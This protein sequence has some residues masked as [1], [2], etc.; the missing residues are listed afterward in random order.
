MRTV[1]RLLAGLVAA[2]VAAGAVT[3]PTGPA[4]AGPVSDWLPYQSTGLVSVA[5]VMPGTV[6][7][8]DG[9]WHTLLLSVN[10]D[11]G[12]SG[13]LV[14]WTCAPGVR[15]NYQDAEEDWRCVADG[16]WE[17]ATAVDEDGRPLVDVRV[18]RGAR[19]LLVEGD[20]LATDYNGGSSLEPIRLVARARGSAVRD[21]VRTDEGALRQITVIRDRTKARGRVLGVR[22]NDPYA[23]VEAS[24]IVAITTYVFPS[25]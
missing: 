9:N 20:V 16:V 8:R 14:D 18:D 10:G 21:V 17:I 1:S 25:A 13:Q 23:S 11:D 4:S 22:V 12:V 5:S 3:L 7:G 6:T 19:R 2:G 15:P 24:S